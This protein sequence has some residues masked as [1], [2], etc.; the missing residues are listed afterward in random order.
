MV[1]KNKQNCVH[2][3][4]EEEEGKKKKKERKKEREKEIKKEKEIPRNLWIQEV[5]TGMRQNVINNME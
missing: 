1:S 4:E 5:T 3:E 2:L